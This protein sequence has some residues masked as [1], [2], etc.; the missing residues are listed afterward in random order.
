MNKIIFTCMC[1]FLII[2]IS[3]AYSL[4]DKT[5]NTNVLEDVFSFS[6]PLI[7]EDGQFVSISLNEA[8]NVCYLPG[9]PNIPRFQK[10]YMFPIGTIFDSIV[11][12]PLDNQQIFLSKPIKPVSSPQ[13]YFENKEDFNLFFEFPN[14]LVYNTSSLYPD[15]QYFIKKGR[16]IVNGSSTIFLTIYYYPIQ[17]DPL[18]NN[19]YFSSEASVKISYISPKPIESSIPIEESYDLVIIAPEE[20]ENTLQPLIIHKNS[21][22]TKTYF[23]SLESIYQ[24]YNGRDEPEQIKN[25]IKDAIETKNINYV[26]LVG[27]IYKTPMR[28]SNVSAFGVWE[29]PVLSDLYYADIYMHDGGFSSWDTDND[30]IFGETGEDILDL[31][32]DVYVGRIPS[33]SIEEASIMVDKIM[34]YEKET[35]GQDWFNNIVYIGGNTFNGLFQFGNEGEKHNEIVMDLMTDF[36]P[37]AVIWT[38]KHNF[39]FWTINRAINKGAGFVDYSGHGFEHGLGTYKPHGRKMKTYLTPYVGFLKNE[40]KLPIF[41]FDACLTA[42]LDFVLQDI[43]DYKQYRLFDLGAKLLKIDTNVKL[44][45]FAYSFL[46][47]EN[48]GAIATIGATRTA[49]GSP[50]FGCELLSIEFFSSYERGLT[51]GEMFASAQHAYINQIPEDEFTIEEFVILGDPSLHIGG[52]STDDQPPEIS[53]VNPIDEYIHVRG[54]PLFKKSVN[55]AF[56]S[57][58]IGGFKAK[59]IQVMIADNIDDPEDVNVY[60]SFK[61]KQSEEMIFNSLK[62]MFELHLSGF[63]FGTYPLEI[64]AIDRSGNKNSILKEISYFCIFK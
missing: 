37:S 57:I 26:L 61:N 16:G 1:I 52:Y 13:T 58:V 49:Y 14:P 35:F 28:M 31:Y 46:R 33:E 45:C 47:H 38:S 20:F 6:N 56:S 10:T 29:H 62:N 54:I 32:P 9:D 64:T 19:M 11:I 43:L 36:D 25:C 39:N 12:E 24:Q 42:K 44:P 3:S 60:L 22:E 59:P 48:G 17:Y 2:P 15:Q 21:I 34:T 30:D 5:S 53:I 8:K 50:S 55:D 41:F 27:S 40:Y 4:S 23:Q 63:G 7:I 18:D 51:L